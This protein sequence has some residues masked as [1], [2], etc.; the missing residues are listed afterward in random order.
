MSIVSPTAE[1]GLWFGGLL[2]FSLLSSN[3]EL[4]ISKWS[5]TTWAGWTSGGEG[6]GISKDPRGDRR[7]MR[8]VDPTLMN[9][10]GL[11]QGEHDGRP[12]GSTLPIAVASLKRRTATKIIPPSNRDPNP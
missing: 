11:L 6:S 2:S 1:R 12:H 3:I 9:V 8:G 10:R 5:S 7:L 4:P